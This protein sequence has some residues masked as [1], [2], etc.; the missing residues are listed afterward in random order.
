MGNTIALDLAVIGLYFAAMAAMGWHFRWRTGATEQFFVGARA[1]VLSIVFAFFALAWSS[2]AGAKETAAQNRQPP[3]QERSVV[4]IEDAQCRIEFGRANGALQRI[5]NRGLGDECL[6]GA[7]TG[8]MPFRIYAD[9]TNEFEIGINNRFQLRFKDPTSITRTVFQPDSVKIEPGADG[10]TLVYEGSGLTIRLEVR[11]TK[12]AGVSDWFLRVTN[13]GQS[14]RE[15]LTC[16]PFLDR[17][18]LGAEPDKDL[19]TAMDHAGLIVP[20]WARDGG[21]LGES[22]DLSMQWHA[23]WDPASRS[24]LSL[25]FMDADVRPK[26]LVLR[27]PSI[28]LHYFPPVTLTPGASIDFPATRLLVYQGDWRRAARAYRAWYDAA[29][30][31]VEPPA[32]FRE[33]NGLNGVHFRKGDRPNYGGQVA[34]Q[35]FRDL[36]SAHI[37]SPIDNWE[38]AFYCQTSMRL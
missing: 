3:K 22:N 19:A 28:A 13:T 10:V 35:N 29:Y 9:L 12:E 33:S 38:Y 15:F 11:R 6:K 20:A 30:P 8:T 32:W 14:P 37:R 7:G 26:R 1:K 24:A 21:V 23:I 2:Q 4:G 5:T 27:K 25:I 17:V 36:P 16:F 18:G 34:L 31:H